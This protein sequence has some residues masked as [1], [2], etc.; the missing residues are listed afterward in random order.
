MLAAQQY[1]D[2]KFRY[3]RGDI[4]VRAFFHRVARIRYLNTDFS[5]EP[6]K[7]QGLEFPLHKF[8]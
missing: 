1:D 6:G 7:L 3:D 2:D 5:S 8:L 4:F